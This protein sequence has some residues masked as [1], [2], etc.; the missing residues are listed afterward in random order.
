MPVWLQIVTA[1]FAVFG[2]IVAVYLAALWW[3]FRR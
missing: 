1:P 2:V 3:E